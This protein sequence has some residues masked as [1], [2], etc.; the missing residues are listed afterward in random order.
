MELRIDFLGTKV[1][2]GGLDTLES[3][4]K[5]TMEVLQ[6]G[7]PGLKKKKAFL[8]IDQDKPVLSQILREAKEKAEKESRNSEQ[9]SAKKWKNYETL[10]DDHHGLVHLEALELLSKQCEI[11][12]KNVQSSLTG[13]EFTDFSETMDQIKELCELPDEDEEEQL[14]LEEIKKKLETAVSEM[15]IQISYEKLVAQ[16]EEMEIWLS[17]IDF[18]V[19]DEKEVHQQAIETL[20]EMTSRAMEQFHKTGELLLIKERRSTSH[21]ADSLV[22]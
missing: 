9:P 14:G 11:K 18:D 13:D 21:E 16:W 7:D 12:L 3:I 22:Q 19:C 2:S 8:K 6:E 15:N 20:A 1:I 17:T 5:K 10:F 4:G